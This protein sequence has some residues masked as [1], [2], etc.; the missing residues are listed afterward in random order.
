M[1]VF[2]KFS[3]L[4]LPNAFAFYQKNFKKMTGHGGWRLV[5]CPFHDDHDP[6]LGINI[7][8][9]SFRCFAC[10]A[11]G[12]DILDFYR[13]LHKVDFITAAKALGAWGNQ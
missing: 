5:I 12:G 13:K 11:S 6:S 3:R 7:D 2:T 8:K 4:R 10:S 9:G 1:K